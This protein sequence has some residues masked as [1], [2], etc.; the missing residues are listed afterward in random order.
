MRRRQRGKAGETVGTGF[1]GGPENVVRLARD[2][3]AGLGVEPLSR[4]REWL[5]SAVKDEG[6]AYRVSE[7]V[8]D[9]QKFLDVGEVEPRRGDP[10]S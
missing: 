2:G 9:G 10:R 5:T 7:A 4:R 6:G 8:E 3:G 1:H